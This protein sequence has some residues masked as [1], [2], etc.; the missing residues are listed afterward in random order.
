[1][2]PLRFLLGFH[3][4][5]PV[6][7]FDHVFAEHLELVYGPLLDTL[8]ERDGFPVTFHVSG[9]LIE[10]LERHAP[11]WL[12]RLGSLVSEGKI[13]LL[14]AGWTEPILAALL[15][16]DRVEQVERMR[17]ELRRRF[18][19][20]ARGLWLTERVWAPDLPADLAHAGITH[21]LVDDRHFL[22]AG[23]ERGTLHRPF[24]TESDN[25]RV[26]VFAIDEHLRYLVPFQPPSAT[27][28]YLRR[29]HTAGQPLA[30][31]ADDGEKFG[32]WPGTFEW[33][34]TKGWFRTFFEEMDRLRTEGI[35]AFGTFESARQDTESGGLVY[36]P[37]ASYREME[38]WSLP[39]PAASRLTSLE[40][41]LGEAWLASEGGA[42][43]RGSHWRNFLVKYPESN[44]MHKK[45]Q[46][47]S[48]LARQRG[49]PEPVRHAIAR[50]QCNDAYW[51]GVFG[52]LYLPHL[53]EAIWRELASAEAALRH[54]E[55][56]TAECLDFD[57]D[58]HDELWVHGAQ[59]S[60]LVSPA[61]GGAVEELTRF[62]L[63][64][65]LCDVL[66]RREEA[67]HALDL[68]SAGGASDSAL[69]SI[70]DLEQRL[71]PDEKPPVDLD[72]RTM[73]RERLLDPATSRDD[74]AAARYTPRVS[75]T[76]VP[77]AWAIET[78]PDGLAIGFRNDD[79]PLGLVKRLTFAPD[80]TLR[81]EYEWSAPHDDGVF[82]VELTLST[83][84]PLEHDADDEWRQ[85]VE[86][87]AKS[88]RGLDRTRQGTGVLLRWPASRGSASLRVGAVER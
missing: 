8:I 9:P 15:H 77:F 39:A 70:H 40:R 27:G 67:Y 82:T 65:N 42:L 75:W 31:L 72:E 44:R 6:G 11:A 28:D 18:G 17:T 24:I 81:A 22:A 37:T 12:E 88:E 71:H 41:Q 16:D 62:A 21:V 80:G 76:G 7:N 33:V 20:E 5:Q 1:M 53:R 66:T 52:G 23:A 30:I 46:H 69:P 54:D 84:V 25:S 61:R 2:A 26:S 14:A 68:S 13:E 34:Y 38:G 64:R 85:P 4:H 73:L 19:V 32:G 86:T 43:V 60:A 35:V 58:G 48:I 51:H 50:A 36:L 29:L 74:Y 10:W 55:P 49:N 3:L 45:A 59:F 87:V 83:D 78:L 56:V 57:F 63:G 79:A 47:L